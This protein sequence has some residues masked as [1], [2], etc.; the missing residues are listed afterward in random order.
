HRISQLLLLSRPEILPP[1]QDDPP[2]RVN[3]RSIRRHSR[4][5]SGLHYAPTLPPHCGHSRRNKKRRGHPCPRR[6]HSVRVSGGVYLPAL[7]SRARRRAATPASPRV[8][9]DNSAK[10][11]GSGTTLVAATTSPLTWMSSTVQ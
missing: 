1:A 2:A 11:A 7:A 5:W 9:I 3:Q 6:P 4:R 10:E 8:P